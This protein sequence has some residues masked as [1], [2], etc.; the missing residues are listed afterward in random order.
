MSAASL[1]KTLY[2]IGVVA[3]TGAALLNQGP[4]TAL[5]VLGLGS[6]LGAFI[7]WGLEQG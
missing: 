6:I 4:A 1:A 7:V 2:G 3:L 5:I